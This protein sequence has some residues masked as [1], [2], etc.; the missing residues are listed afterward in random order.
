[1]REVI[2]RILEEAVWAP[3]GDNSQPWSFRIKDNSLDIYAHPERD[4][5]FLNVEGRGTYLAIGALVENIIIA[6]REY[7]FNATITQ[8]SAPIIQVAFASRGARGESLYRAIRERHTHRGAYTSAEIPGPLITTLRAIGEE[9]ARVAVAVEPSRIR[10]IADAASLMEETALRTKKIHRL[11]FESLLW[12]HDDAKKGAP[13]LYIK[14]TEL[15]PPVQILFRVIRH[16]PIMRTLNILGFSR[17]AAKSNAVVYA[18]STACIAVILDRIEPQDFVNAGR[19]MQRAW[20]QLTNAGFAAQPLAG[21]LYLAEYLTRTRDP[22]IAD[23]LK[24]RI[25][26]AQRVITNEFGCRENETIAMVLRAGRPQKPA[27]ARTSR[28]APDFV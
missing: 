13:G 11:F 3:S 19:C 8:T 21:L 26:A 17:F 25:V 14:T 15:P 4:H 10:A 9:H 24:E 2:V 27:T 7:G 1:M 28:M 20:L 23:G 22:D 12:S 16:W 5:A 18:K 6:A